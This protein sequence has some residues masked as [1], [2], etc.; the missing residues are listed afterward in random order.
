MEESLKKAFKYYCEE[1]LDE[2]VPPTV[3][4]LCEMFEIDEEILRIKIQR[5]NWVQIR[6]NNHVKYLQT[7]KEQGEIIAEGKAISIMEA[8]KSIIEGSVK[9]YKDI[10]E[11]I[12]DRI[13][14]ALGNLDF[15]DPR[16]FDLLVKLKS[17]LNTQG[18]NLASQLIKLKEME[19]A[20]DN[21]ISE[22]ERRVKALQ[23]FI[24]KPKEDEKVVVGKTNF[25]SGLQDKVTSE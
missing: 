16:S 25:L 11:K 3:E 24:N 20:G 10:S 17:V 12:D 4:E 9:S 5:S 19:S 14:K 18:N 8:A 7:I 21:S 22:E 13:L 23:E 15:D 6:A 1:N 2:V